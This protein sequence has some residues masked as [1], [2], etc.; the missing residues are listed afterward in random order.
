[1]SAAN[2]W[3]CPNASCINN[4]KLVFGSKSTCPKCGSN[5]EE[6]SFDDFNHTDQDDQVLPQGRSDSVPQGSDDWQCPNADCINHDKMVFGKKAI[7]PACGAARDAK[8][9]GDWAC[10]NA[11]C[12]NAKNTVFASKAVCPR[13]GSARPGRNQGGG[14]FRGGC[15]PAI[16]PHMP[17]S[18]MQRT[19]VPHFATAPHFAA[20]LQNIQAMI[21][22][23][24]NGDWKCPDVSCVNNKNMVFGR[25]T[26]CPRCGAQ[27]AAAQG[28]GN[29][30]DW[31][32]PKEEC[33]NHKNKVFA[34]H[35]SCPSC[36]TAK[37]DFARSRSPHRRFA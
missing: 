13:C 16:V 36:G 6:E 10:P 24:Q 5:K 4:T 1:M 28:K 19:L 7:C 25:H 11:A 27:K 34:K 14:G 22:A 29:P 33:I 26:A 2:D 9:P 32:C 31:K 30:G 15:A 17:F 3:A 20:A 37:N 8:N 18:A 23:A 21:P 12:I 35:D